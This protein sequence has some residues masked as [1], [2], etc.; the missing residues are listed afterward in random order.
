MYIITSIAKKKRNMMN[1]A[2]IYNRRDIPFLD[3]TDR[4]K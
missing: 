1:Q 2:F 3:E 4:E